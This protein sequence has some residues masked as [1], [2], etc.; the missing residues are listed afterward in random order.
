MELTF[1]GITR[2][3]IVL[4]VWPAITGKTLST[5]RFCSDLHAFIGIN[6]AEQRGAP[7]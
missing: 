4:R 3:S 7:T 6:P 2:K 1:T 5:I